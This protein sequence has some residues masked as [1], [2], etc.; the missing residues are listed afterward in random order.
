[1]HRP[2]KRP[3]LQ[4][5][6]ALTKKHA[7]APEQLSGQ[8]LMKLREVLYRVQCSRSEWYR[9]VAN[10]TAPA[11]V[12]LGEHASAFVSSEIDQWIAERIAA[13]DAKAAA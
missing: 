12:K 3:P 7:A 9:K 5:A 1:M 4:A 8:R 10:G 2:V 13:R 6:H 11:P